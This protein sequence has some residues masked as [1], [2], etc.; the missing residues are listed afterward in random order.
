MKPTS[1]FSCRD[2]ACAVVCLMSKF[3][4]V[5]A[6]SATSTDTHPLKQ[7]QMRA[8]RGS[9]SVGCLAA[10]FV[11]LVGLVCFF[12]RFVWFG[13]LVFLVGFTCLVGWFGLVG[14]FFQ[15]HGRSIVLFEVLLLNCV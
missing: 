7:P 6:W 14:W 5:S 3:S 8:C 12:V 13:F 9:V 4:C 1:T 10:W 11:W 15:G 2:C